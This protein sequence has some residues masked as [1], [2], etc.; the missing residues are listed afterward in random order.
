LLKAVK[1]RLV[2][3][4]TRKYRIICSWILLICFVAGQFMVYT[5]QH[6]IPQS[7]GKS[8]DIS[9]NFSQQT[10]KEKCYL[11]D[12]MH[13]NTMD[14]ASRV[15]FGTTVSAGYV[16]NDFKYHFTSIQI[17]LSSGRAPPFSI[18]CV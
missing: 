6:N 2:D 13:H 1:K 12:V 16:F 15:H 11:C 8:I 14:I 7:A 4:K 10:V 9:K 17:I 3:L 18:Y 5:H